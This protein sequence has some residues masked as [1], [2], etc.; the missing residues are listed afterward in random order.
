MGVASPR[1]PGRRAGTTV[2]VAAAGALAGVVAIAARGSIWEGSGAS[3]PQHDPWRPVLAAVQALAGA[4]MVAALVLATAG[5]LRRGGGAARPPRRRSVWGQ[6]AALVVAALLAMALGRDEGERSG[7]GGAEGTAP[8]PAPEAEPA[9][10]DEGGGGWWSFGALGAATALAAVVVVAVAVA[11]RR[12]GAGPDDAGD[13]G[14][15]D[16]VLPDHLLRSMHAS[17]HGDLDPRTGVLAAWAALEVHLAGHGLA[18]RPSEAPREYIVRVLPTSARR[19][20]LVELTGLY[21]EARFS[22]HPIDEGARRRAAGL[23][24]DLVMAHS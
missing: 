22:P 3:A 4:A 18:R 19:D 15:G 20:A 6:V 2:P 9:T 5:L 7:A 14:Q 16:D 10:G 1:R 11:R 8:A 24:A 23:L 13:E 21:E 12:S 17:L